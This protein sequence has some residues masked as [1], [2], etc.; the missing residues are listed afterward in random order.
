MLEKFVSPVPCPRRPC[1]KL[2]SSYSLCLLQVW[3]SHPYS[4][5]HIM[6]WS[7]SQVGRNLTCPKPYSWWDQSTQHI[8]AGGP[9]W[10]PEIL[11]LPVT[12]LIYFFYCNQ[13]GLSLSPTQP[14]L[15]LVIWSPLYW[16]IPCQAA[17]LRLLLFAWCDT[18]TFAVW[19]NKNWQKPSSSQSWWGFFSSLW[20]EHCS[21]PD[22]QGMMWTSKLL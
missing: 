12:M 10:S 17:G 14:I 1:A 20:L 19:K 6:C 21:S 11:C 18:V 5:C 15:K 16:F 7:C 3:R 13:V 22:N 2:Y 9:L 8:W 4:A